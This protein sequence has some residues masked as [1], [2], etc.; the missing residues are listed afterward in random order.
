MND[1]A[2]QIRT[3]AFARWAK[4]FLKAF[5]RTPPPVAITRRV[6]DRSLVYCVGDVHGRDDLLREMAG[7][8]EV[9]MT[10]R[11]FDSAVTVFLGDYIDRGP[12]SKAVI[13][14]LASREWPTPIIALAGNHE[15]FLLTFL[16]EPGSLDFWRSQGGLQT[17]HSY[18]VNVRSAM[19]GREFEEIQ[20][21][22]TARLP[23]Q[24]QD[25]LKALKASESIGDY[26]FCHAGVRPG[27]ALDCQDRDDLLNI[28]EPFLSSESEHGRLVVHGHTPAV[29]PEIRPN[30]IGIDT[31][32]YATGRLT[33]LVLEKD[34]QRFLPA[35]N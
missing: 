10:S 15:E 18:G 35:A 14:R 16:D 20:A 23:K 34:E 17:L 19:A 30:R 31:G 7:R 27:V 32:A 1:P 2:A 6:P 25:F 24:H 11:S 26:F 3:T 4:P 12:D 33:C 22:F 29:A 21:E 28:R 8:V 13:E 5:E 9:D